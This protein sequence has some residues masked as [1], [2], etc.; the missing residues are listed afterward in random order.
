MAVT[1][2]FS[3][4]PQNHTGV[5]EA[6]TLSWLSFNHKTKSAINTVLVGTGVTID[7]GRMVQHDQNS[8]LNGRS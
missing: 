5:A 2:Y 1:G 8:I 6:Q 4:A 3:S 7:R